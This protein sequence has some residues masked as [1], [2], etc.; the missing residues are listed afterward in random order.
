MKKQN[1]ARLWIRR[2]LVGAGLVICVFLASACIKKTPAP[3]QTAPPAPPPVATSTLISTLEPT[4]TQPI[5]AVMT[6]TMEKTGVC[7]ISV[8]IRSDNADLVLRYK[9]QIDSVKDYAIAAQYFSLLTSSSRILLGASIAVMQKMMTDLEAA[10]IPYDGIAY[11]LENWVQT[12]S[13]EQSDPVAASKQAADL[14]HAHG[15]SLIMVPGMG[16]MIKHPQYYSGMAANADVWVIQ[17]QGVQLKYPAG[18][19]Y[20]NFIMDIISKIRAGNSDVPIWVQISVTPGQGAPMSVETLMAYR[21]TI[22]NDITGTSLFDR[23]DPNKPA[24]M[25]GVLAVICK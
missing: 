6:P 5:M 1:L 25:Q 9:P 24:T 21:N 2:C 3:T 7:P 17:S 14:A 8:T 20:R 23:N 15:K 18:P 10:K 19:D 4:A 16:F 12:P 11:D 22:I 13:T